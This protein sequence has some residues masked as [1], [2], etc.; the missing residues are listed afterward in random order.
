MHDTYGEVEIVGRH[1]PTSTKVI[2]KKRACLPATKQRA[3]VFTDN[4]SRPN[5]KPSDGASNP[6][7]TNAH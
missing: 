2:V 4:L 1:G 7:G 3:I 5:G 6:K